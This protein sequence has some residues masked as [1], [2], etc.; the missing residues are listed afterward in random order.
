M[1]V[2]PAPLLEEFEGLRTEVTCALLPSW[3]LIPQ[4]SVHPVMVNVTCR[5]GWALVPVVWANTS[6]EVAVKVFCNCDQHLNQ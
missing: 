6:L 3:G 5:L 1:I 2:F 4:L